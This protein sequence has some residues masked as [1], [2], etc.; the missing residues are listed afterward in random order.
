MAESCTACVAK[1]IEHQ[2]AGFGRRTVSSG[3]HS[4]TSVA[5][6]TTSQLHAC[7]PSTRLPAPFPQSPF[8]WVKESKTQIV[9]VAPRGHLPSSGC[10]PFMREDG[11]ATD[12]TGSSCTRAQ[13]QAPCSLDR[14]RDAQAPKK[15]VLWSGGTLAHHQRTRQ[16]DGCRVQCPCAQRSVARGHKAVGAGGFQKRDRGYELTPQR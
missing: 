7:D 15:G 11:R 5:D 8:A 9:G 6:T 2:R 14:V 3:S 10:A 16:P 4:P 12:G 13:R 1:P